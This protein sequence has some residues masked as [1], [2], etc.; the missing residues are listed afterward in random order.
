M[1]PLA[2]LTQAAGIDSHHVIDP[3]LLDRV[4][5]GIE[6]PPGVARPY[7]RIGT[8]CAAASPGPWQLHIL[9]DW[10]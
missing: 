8:G 7:Q 4:E 6:D 10:C 9:G 2:E 3:G 1:Q 5:L